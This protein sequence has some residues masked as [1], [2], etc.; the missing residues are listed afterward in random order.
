MTIN[1]TTNKVIALGNGVT[2]NFTFDFLIPTT[3]D[4][5]V[6]YTDSAGA[7]TTL[8]SSQYSVSGIGNDDGGYVTYPIAGS[9]IAS[10]TTL[11]ILRVVPFT[12]EVEIA[13]Q[14]NFYPQSVETALDALE[15]QIQQLNET[16]SRA[17]LVPIT[18]GECPDDATEFTISITYPVTLE[19]TRNGNGSSPSTGVSGDLPN[20]PFNGTI[21]GWT[22]RGS[23][24]GS[25]ELDI[26]KNT[27]AIGDPPVVGDS[28]CASAYPALSSAEAND[29]VASPMTGWTTT[30]T[31][32]DAFRFNIRSITTVTFFTLI[33]SVNRTIGV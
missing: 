24:S 4:L 2:T 10:G 29:S 6:I 11:T 5:T 18:S 20:I 28:I 8:V 13:N 15:M 30:V 7:S 12:Q 17:P 19:H 33:V 23:P 1:T 21:T 26:W 32:G 3:E 25:L 16:I 27:F 22:L 14:G 31:A 9:P